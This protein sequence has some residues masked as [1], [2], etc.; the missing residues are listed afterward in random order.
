MKIG[1]TIKETKYYT[2]E[3]KGVVICVITV[4]GILG[5]RTFTGKAKCSSDDTFDEAKGRRIAESRAKTKLYGIAQKTYQCVASTMTKTLTE[6]TE[7]EQFCKMLAE[8][9][10]T[11]VNELCEK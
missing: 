9:E 10:R 4:E 5:Y 8:K 6:I 2:N 3:K 1:I 7:K 11:H